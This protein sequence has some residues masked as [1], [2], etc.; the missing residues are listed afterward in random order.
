M[1]FPDDS[2]IIWYKKGWTIKV[3]DDKGKKI[4]P[5]GLLATSYNSFRDKFATMKLFDNGKSS[6]KPKTPKSKISCDG[7]LK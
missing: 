1:L 7:T 3:G 5:K 4:N 6:S 2:L